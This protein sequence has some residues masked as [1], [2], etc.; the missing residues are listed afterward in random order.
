V[1]L[2]TL[3]KTPALSMTPSPPKA[4][5][6]GQLH[7]P[8]SARQRS[9]CRK[10]ASPL[11][12][13][14]GAVDAQKSPIESPSCPMCCDLAIRFPRNAS[15]TATTTARPTWLAAGP[16]LSTRKNENWDSRLVLQSRKRIIIKKKSFLACP[17][18]N[19]TSRICSSPNAFGN[20]MRCETSFPLIRPV[21]LF[22]ANGLGGT[23]IEERFCCNHFGLLIASPTRLT[24]HTLPHDLGELCSCRLVQTLDGLEIWECQPGV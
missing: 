14:L 17:A 24:I 23:R 7:S 16:A 12:G 13:L 20:S 18:C 11:I 6:R 21:M 4:P 19:S 15:Q 8:L 9:R 3:S 22:S 10:C 5:N 2:S 1:G